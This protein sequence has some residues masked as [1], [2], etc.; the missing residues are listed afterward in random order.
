MSTSVS[1][2]DH[3]LLL[4]MGFLV[5]NSFIITAWK[6]EEQIRESRLCFQI[7]WSI[8]IIFKSLS[9]VVIP[10][11]FLPWAIPAFI[12][13]NFVC[14]SATKL[15]YV[16]KAEVAPCLLA[17]F[18]FPP[19]LWL[20]IHRSRGWGVFL[21]HSAQHVHRIA[22]RLLCKASWLFLTLDSSRERNSIIKMLL[23][24]Y[25]LRIS[26]YNLKLFCIGLAFMD[27]KTP[28]PIQYVMKNQFA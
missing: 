5:C 28:Y 1:F 20:N 16:G 17:Q 13:I 12:T 18:F 26:W 6:E 3:L 24:G 27:A 21:L 10:E 22:L 11:H 15:F 25:E 14:S 8:S 23:L 2:L 7:I 4:L 19:P 9:W